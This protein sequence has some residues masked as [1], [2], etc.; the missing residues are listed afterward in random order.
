MVNRYWIV[1]VYE[2][3]YGFRIVDTFRI[4]IGIVSKDDQLMLDSRCLYNRMKIQD[5]ES[6]QDINR[7]KD[8]KSLLVIMSIWDIKLLYDSKNFSDIYRGNDDK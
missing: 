8:G 2:I 6:F 4:I 3:Y 1:S 7:K 5:G